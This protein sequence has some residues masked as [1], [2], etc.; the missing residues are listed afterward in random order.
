MA[1]NP[2]G[3]IY[4][5]IS[6]PRTGTYGLLYGHSI[7]SV[8]ADGTF[9][10]YSR[11]F[12]LNAGYARLENNIELA[13]DG[14][15]NVYIVG[16]VYDTSGLKYTGFYAR[17]GAQS[18]G[19]AGTVAYAASVTNTANC[20]G[21]SI[22]CDSA[23]AYPTF[24]RTISGLERGVIAK[25]GQDDVRSFVY[26]AVDAQGMSIVGSQL[27]FSTGLGSFG[28][29]DTDGQT[30]TVANAYTVGVAAVSDQHGYV[31]DGTNMVKCQR[32]MDNMHKTNLTSAASLLTFG[33]FTNFAWLPWVPALEDVT[34]QTSNTPTFSMTQW[35]IHYGL[36]LQ[37]AVR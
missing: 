37:R 16:T 28:T 13:G 31:F 1:I 18:W 21:G 22:V 4:V 17:L 32:T 2:L 11:P 29:L 26:G 25:Y 23:N 20:Y 35:P 10:D 7:L 6:V 36:N 15:G 24:R 9:V 27:Y 12:E 3:G 33:N 30:L 8:T 14:S 19:A 34:L 5:G